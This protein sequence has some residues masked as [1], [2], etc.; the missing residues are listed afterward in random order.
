MDNLTHSL[1]GL[2]IAKAGLERLSPGAATVCVIAANAPDFDAL[3]LLTGRWPYVQHH[4]GI[5][6]S[7]VGVLILAVLVPTVFY[8]GDFLLA[9]LRKRPRRIRYAGLLLASLIASATHPLMDWTN[10]YGIRLLLPW[11]GKWFYG[12]LVF[13]IDPLIWIVLGGAGF[14]LASRTKAQLT[15]W[16]IMALIL[17]LLILLLPQRREAVPHVAAFRVGWVLIL[18]GLFFAR[19]AR[20][21]ERF[22]KSLALA[23]MAI[24]LAYWGA[25]GF[26]HKRAYGQ[27][28]VIA[29]AIAAQQGE[30]LSQVAAMPA[31]ADPIHW[32]C[33]SDTDRATYR[34]QVSVFGNAQSPAGFERF[35]K[36]KPS[37]LSA[38]GAASRDD[39]AKIF[40]GVARFPLVQVKDADC[41]SQTVVQFVDL[42]YTEPGAARRGTFSLEVPIAC[43][44]PTPTHAGAVARP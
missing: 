15:V 6:H 18:A 11:S 39:R 17:T 16:S 37:G 7:I 35:E 31:L 21:G 8:V 38:I 10:N 44:E 33:I 41:V 19:R 25:L 30:V 34:F 24:V 9:K 32:Q 36:P 12:D 27:A 5:T 20:L 42:R 26:A 40:L 22:G 3:V 43:P 29:N 1:T 23:A 4:R 28:Q 2:V 14:L 13:I